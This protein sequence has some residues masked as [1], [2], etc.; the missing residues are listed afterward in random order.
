MA[1][2][3]S[4]YSLQQGF[5][6]A[7]V[8]PAPLSNYSGFSLVGLRMQPPFGPLSST[9]MGQLT[10]FPGGSAAT[11]A[12]AASFSMENLRVAQGLRPMLTSG[13]ASPGSLG[14]KRTGVTDFSIDGILG[15]RDGDSQT[16]NRLE[17]IRA[18]HKLT[19]HSKHGVSYQE[20]HYPSPR[21][22]IDDNQE[23]TSPHKMTV[24]DEGDGHES[25]TD[26][27]TAENPLAR[28]SWLQCTRYKPPRLP[29]EYH[30]NLY[31]THFN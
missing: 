30:V 8:F 4:A 24:D 20:K 3:N 9:T 14:D 27:D 21:E 22:C 12:A 1:L 25:K 6:A 13:A 19:L 28:F 26:T 23:A 2:L 10:A 29:R 7:G 5:Y 31:F 17:S 15:K 16:S 18:K 11:I